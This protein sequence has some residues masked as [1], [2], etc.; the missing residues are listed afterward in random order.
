[1]HEYGIIKDGNFNSYKNILLENIRDIVNGNYIQNHRWYDL[2]NGLNGNLTFLLQYD[3][4]QI[5]RK[6][7]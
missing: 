5:K 4:I 6:S 7:A 3:D 2:F 1:M